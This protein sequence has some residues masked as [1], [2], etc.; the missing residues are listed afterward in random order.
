MPPGG[1]VEGVAVACAAPDGAGADAAV[2]AGRL[3]QPAR[4]TTPIKSETRIPFRQRLDMIPPFF[5][6]ATRAVGLLGLRADTSYHGSLG[7]HEGLVK[8]PGPRVSGI[9]AEPSVNI[10]KICQEPSRFD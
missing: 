3:A 5:A 4:T 2:I 9:C 7:D 10:V 1:V 8:S 6:R